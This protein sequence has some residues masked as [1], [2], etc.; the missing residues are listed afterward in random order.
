MVLTGTYNAWTQVGSLGALVST[1]YGRLLSVKLILFIILTLRYIAP[2]QHGQ[3]ESAFADKFLRRSRVDAG[4]MLVIILCA[5]MLTHGV[6]AKHFEHVISHQTG[7][8]DSGHDME[9]AE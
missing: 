2:P 4:I 8:M 9:H 1:P 3:D 5:A 6:P 7:S